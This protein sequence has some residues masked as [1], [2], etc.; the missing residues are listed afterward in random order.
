MELLSHRAIGAA[1]WTAN[2][3]GAG[4]RHLFAASSLSDHADGWAPPYQ[5]I[6]KFRLHRTAPT[7]PRRPS[8]AAEAAAAAA[9]AAAYRPAVPVRLQAMVGMRVPLALPPK[10]APVSSAPAAAPAAAGG[11]LPPAP[12]AAGALPGAAPAASA[13]ADSGGAVATTPAG[14]EVGAAAAPPPR[15]PRAASPSL[16]ALE[17]LYL[18][19]GAGTEVW[20]PG[21]G[22]FAQAPVFIPYGGARDDNGWLLVMTHDTH[23]R[24]SAL[25][26]LDAGRV[27]EGPVCVISLPHHLPPARAAQFTHAYLGP[28]R[29]APQGWRP[30][31]PGAA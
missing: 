21:P 29:G 11:A 7:G 28:G 18:G 27:S 25:C 9:E 30:D 8:A 23:S 17:G 13:A 4:P 16:G 24:T 20:A 31:A 5:A 26:I 22:R 14:G 19:H 2:V 1:A 10:E 6:V 12:G 3:S 15:Q